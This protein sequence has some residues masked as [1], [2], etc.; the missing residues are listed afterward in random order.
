M[1]QSHKIDVH[2]YI[3]S[4]K[5]HFTRSNFSFINLTHACFKQKF[6]MYWSP[7][8]YL[9]VH[10]KWL[11]MC[12]DGQLCVWNRYRGQVWS[13]NEGKFYHANTL[14]DF[15]FFSRLIF[16][17]VNG[18]SLQKILEN[19]REKNCFD[20]VIWRLLV[21]LIKIYCL[22]KIPFLPCGWNFIE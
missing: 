22:S 11:T 9:M 19:K 20:S 10:Q 3:K 12:L 17:F 13:E 16:T 6:N 1:A 18:Q 8:R 5:M 21:L 15:S 4:L 7:S 2:N 14:L